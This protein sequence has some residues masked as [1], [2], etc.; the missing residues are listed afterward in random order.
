MKGI[1]NAGLI[2][3]ELTDFQ[4]FYPNDWFSFE[5]SPDVTDLEAV[6]YIEGIQQTVASGEGKVTHNFT[7]STQL[8][9]KEAQAI[10]YNQVP[11]TFSG[12]IAIVESFTVPSSSPYELSVS[13]VT[14]ANLSLIG[15]FSDT[16]GPLEPT[17][18]ASTAP[19]DGTEV[20]LDTTNNKIIFHSSLA[21]T[22]GSYTKPTVISS[23]PSFGGAGAATKLGRLKFLG[24]EYGWE[25]ED[26]GYVEFPALDRV[27]RPTISFT[28]DVPTF[29]I[30]FRAAVPTGWSDPFRKI[31][32]N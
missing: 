13:T 31:F 8:V 23:K 28:G 12:T 9:K 17:A 18:D 7:L 30:A 32:P 1:G 10:I 5:Y 16:N 20:Q 29:E 22:T 2:T 6:G 15:V 27:G 3:T 19:A 25:S 21:G 24:K 26:D 11:K 4:R 14:A